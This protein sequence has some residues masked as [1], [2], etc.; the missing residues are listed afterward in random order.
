MKIPGIAVARGWANSFEVKGKTSINEYASFLGWNFAVIIGLFLAS[1]SGYLPPLTPFAYLAADALPITS[2]TLRRLNDAE[3]PWSKLFNRK[4]LKQNPSKER[5]QWHTN[6]IT[7]DLPE[8][9]GFVLFSWG[10]GKFGV[11]LSVIVLIATG[12]TL[13]ASSFIAAGILFLT[14][15]AII[16]YYTKIY[17]DGED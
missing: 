5:L 15:A 1:Y 17:L 7:R 4:A 3:E 12:I 14:A 16:T 6:F 10:P 8:L 2:L 9:P 13:I 11:G